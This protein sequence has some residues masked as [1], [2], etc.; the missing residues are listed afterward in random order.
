MNTE[1]VTPFR[2]VSDFT[3]AGD[4]PQAICALMKGLEHNTRDQ[5]LLGVT[6]SGKTFTMAHVIAQYQ[7]PTLIMAPN[8]TLAAQLYSEMK[9]FFPHNAVEYFVSY[10]DYYRPEAYIPQSDTYIEK[11]SAINDAIDRMRHS[12]TRAILERKDVIIVASVSCIYG[13]GDVQSY[14]ESKRIFSRNQTIDPIEACRTLTSL[15]YTRTLDIARG[16][17]RL[18]GDVLEIFP[19]HYEH[20]A[21]RVHFFGDLIENIEEI[22]TRSRAVQTHLDHITIYANSH[23]VTPTPTIRQAIEHIKIDLEKRLDEFRANNQY[24]ESE[25]LE[26][27][28]KFD[29]EMLATTGMCHGIENYSR[30][31]TGRPSGSPPPTL[32]EYMPSNALLIVDESH[33]AVPQVRAMYKGDFA[34]KSV[35]SEYGFRLPS[36]VDNRPLKFE[37]WQ[38]FRPKTIF[39]SATP[40]PFELEATQGVV[41]EQVIRPTGLLDPICSVHPTL[42]QMDHL[43]KHAHETVQAGGRI[44]ITTLTKRMAES[45]STFIEEAGFKSC[46]MH[47]DIDTLDRIDILHKLRQGIF[48]IL[49]GINLLREGIDLPECSLVCILD[50]DKEGYLRTASSL[51]QTIGRAARNANGR[52]LLYADRITAA[53]ELA[54]QETTRRRQIQE[55]YNAEHGITPRTILKALHVFEHGGTEESATKSHKKQSAYQNADEILSADEITKRMHQAAAALNFEEAAAWRDALK[56][57]EG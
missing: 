46:Y 20:T 53:M 14:S 27:K 32:F 57:L 49:I 11:E 16:T 54:L 45:L 15:H 52:V 10:Y 23:Y 26:R 6:G 51:I 9:G 3:P 17:F 5:V 18:Q 30:Y 24:T 48:D 33:V 38:D 43:L 31:L 55:K 37:E 44:L 35:L 28:V 4:Q 29:I 12:A 42:N 19:S 1:V 8:K 21:W 56:N 40:G 2:I 50:A 25:R 34:R 13:L 22:D 47:S 36:C 39:V 41:V 7:Q